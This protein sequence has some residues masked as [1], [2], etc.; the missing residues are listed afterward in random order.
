MKTDALAK[1]VIING[2]AIYAGRWW[3]AC[4]N[5]IKNAVTPCRSF[6]NKK[7]GSIAVFPWCY[8]AEESWCVKKT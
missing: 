8:E 6:Q 1:P 5:S 3:G 7:R 4:L 2:G